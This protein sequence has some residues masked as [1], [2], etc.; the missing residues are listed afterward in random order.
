MNVLRRNSGLLHNLMSP[1]L[2]TVKPRLSRC[3]LKTVIELDG[4]TVDLI[5]T[6][7]FLCICLRQD[8]T[9]ESALII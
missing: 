3:G 8:A 5:I 4:G 2:P 6:T 1:F 9:S 7:G